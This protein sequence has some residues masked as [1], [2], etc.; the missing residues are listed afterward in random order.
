MTE[1][2]SLKIFIHGGR[3]SLAITTFMKINH[4]A[5]KRFPDKNNLISQFNITKAIA[6]DPVSEIM[7]VGIYTCT[8]YLSAE[9]A[10][11]C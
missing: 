8:F 2:C 9:Q 11:C 3:N 4:F 5:L 10:P 1:Y 6:F 7:I